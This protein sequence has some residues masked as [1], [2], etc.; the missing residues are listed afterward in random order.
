VKLRVIWVG[1]T[2]QEW[3]RAGID[4]YTTRIR[5]YFPLEIGE[6]REEKR[7]LDETMRDR[8]CARLEKLLPKAARLVLLD[9]RG[10]G[11]SSRDFA[12][13]LEKSRDG[14]IPELAFA[15]G[16][17]YGF[18]DAFRARADTVISLSCMT[19]THQM[20]RVFLLEQIYRGCT[21]LNRE[22]YHH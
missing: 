19:F 10:K 1:K 5:R 16:G 14:G 2:Q 13:F 18:S 3:V 8:E 9:E 17:A 6:A 12:G 20:A 11:M 4:E 7:A 21:I 22:P 15:I